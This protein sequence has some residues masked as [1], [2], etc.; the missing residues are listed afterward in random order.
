MWP[1]GYTRERFDSD[2]ERLGKMVK[3]NRGV[4]DNYTIELNCFVI[5]LFK[6]LRARLNRIDV[7]E[8]RDKLYNAFLK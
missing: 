2:M 4:P 5:P 6:S 1:L 8:G 7:S 3:E